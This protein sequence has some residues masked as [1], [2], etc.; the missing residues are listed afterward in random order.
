MD[1][2]GWKVYKE[3]RKRYAKDGELICERGPDKQYG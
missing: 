3:Q 1:L 2:N